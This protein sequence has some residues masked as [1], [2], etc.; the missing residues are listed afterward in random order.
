MI[1]DS[2]AACAGHTMIYY[3]IASKTKYGQA[4]PAHLFIVPMADNRNAV[5]SEAASA[6]WPGAGG[7]LESRN[8]AATGETWTCAA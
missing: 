6:G 5:D 8:S 3:V 1:P 2:I 4:P 7:R